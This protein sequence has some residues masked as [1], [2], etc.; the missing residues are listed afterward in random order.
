[1]RDLPD[2]E[3]RI[4]HTLSDGERKFA[5]VLFA[6]IVNSSDLVADADPEEANDL[7]LPWLRAMVEAVDSYGGTV[8][9]LLGDGIMAL[10]GAPTAQ[11]HHAVRACLAAQE[12]QRRCAQTEAQRVPSA[13]QVR[14]GISSGEIMTQSIRSGMLEE[15]RAV[16]DSVYLASRTEKAAQPGQVL[17]TEETYR[18]IAGQIDVGPAPMVR[19]NDNSRSFQAYALKDVTVTKRRMRPLESQAGASFVGREEDLTAL[20]NSLARARDGEGEIFV[21]T[22]EAGVGKSRLVEEHLSS[23]DTAEVSVL[24]ADLEP[25]GV[26]RFEDAIARLVRSLL[27]IEPSTDP[28]QIVE[29]VE[30][31]LEALRLRV[32]HNTAAVLDV[33]GHT[34]KDPVW[35]GIDPPQRLR[36]TLMAI[37]DIVRMSSRRRPLILILEDFHWASSEVQQL[38]KE[39]AA[40]LDATRL[41][42]IITSRTHHERPWLAW[43]R[44]VQH[45][46]RALRP[47][48]AMR[49]VET[50]LGPTDDG[51]LVHRLIEKTQGNPF[52]I[53]ECVRALVERDALEGRPG[54]YRLAVSI[55]EIDF[56]FTVHGVLAERIDSLARGDRRTLLCAAVI[57]K[58]FDVKL[59]E[60][61]LNGGEGDLQE[62]LSRLEEQGFLQRTR[63]VPNVEYGFRHTLIHEVVYGTLLKRDRLRLHAAVMRDIRKRPSHELSVKWKSLAYHAFLGAEW[64]QAVV[65][66]RIAAGK[67]QAASRNAEATSLYGQALQA[68][69]ELPDSTRNRQRGIDIRLE[70]VQSFFT[71][72]Q[73]GKARE[74][75]EAS[76]EIANE[77]GDELRL[78]R[79]LSAR[80]VTH[81]I[82]GDLGQA[83]KAGNLALKVG[84]RMKD[85]RLTIQVGTRL[86]S[87][88]IDEG[89]Y[90]AACVLL[91]EIVDQIP[92]TAEE[93]RFGVLVAASV[94]C[95]ASLARALGELG[96]F[97]EA[98]QVGDEAVQLAE[99]IGHSF[100]QVY[101][102][103]FVGNALFRKGDFRTSQHLFARA[104]EACQA[105]QAHLL[106]PLSA[107]ALG[108]ALIKTGE[109][110]DGLAL[111]ES[112]VR[113]ANEHDCLF[114]LSQQT[115]WLAEGYLHA[116]DIQSA[117]NQAKLAI[118]MAREN[119][120]KGEEAWAHW[121]M[122]EILLASQK[123]TT[124]KCA[125]AFRQA[126]AIAE[127]NKM[128]PLVAHCLAGL[129]RLEAGRGSPDEALQLSE[130]ASEQYAALDM[131]AFLHSAPAGLSS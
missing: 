35:Q 96:R 76:A 61:L 7:L 112:A 38:A 119:G 86:G 69:R 102:Y 3:R 31:R 16:G 2:G 95:R 25:T 73:T 43:P 130:A 70:Q 82:D 75:L 126:L 24:K 71:L 17:L 9:Q 115:T 122:G 53:E 48:D 1:M 21:I 116:G 55:D 127:E 39:I 54:Q 67:A 23:V 45:R 123:R 91:R 110:T 89:S 44:V 19:L 131:S 109:P 5:T 66:C 59:L 117:L 13:V 111:L 30:E 64:P 114:Q 108:Y 63:I 29:R 125:K 41:Q 85:R 68:L 77:L 103:I 62:R 10:F 80:M 72:G 22:G 129:S 33:L 93:E 50:L 79:I 60:H 84:K 92:H 128:A 12:I 36:L 74:L 87:L 88:Y 107:A 113:Q 18:L 101:A 14:V 58:D 121:V 6:D 90:E 11:E 52:F 20:Q 4:A 100:S 98:M 28:A 97:R 56:P 15:Y 120:E 46:V 124:D 40:R 32:A 106:M 105:T 57:G 118:A 26:P 94:G 37:A 99:E 42:L 47:E 65:Y 49:F 81:W 51:A 27:N 78:A 34:A 83:I 104:H 8:T